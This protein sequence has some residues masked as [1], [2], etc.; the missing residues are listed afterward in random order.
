MHSFRSRIRTSLHPAAGLKRLTFTLV[1]LLGATVAAHA[2][3]IKIAQIVSLTGPLEA[4]GKQSVNGFMLGLEYATGGTM[5][6]GDRKIVV[7]Q[8]DDQSKPDLA[9]AL[10]T[11]A[12]SD[13]KADIGVGGMTTATTLVLLPVAEEHKKILIVDSAISDS[14]TSER[15]NKYLFRVKQNST[16][17]AAPSAAVVDESDTSVA[18]LAQ[19]TTFGREGAAAFKAALTKAKVVHEE[20]VAPM[21]NDF[22]GP[23]QRLIDRLKSLPG[24][25]VIFV[26]TW[27]GPNDPFKIG[28]AGLDRFGI[29]VVAGANI[30][31]AMSQYKRFP[32]ML[33]GI[34]YYY[35]IPKNPTND[36]LVAQHK[37]RFGSPPD[38]YQAYSFAAA[39]AIVAGLTKSKGD[40][41]GDK[42]SIMMEGLSFE[43]PKGTMTFRPQDHQ[44][45][46]SMYQYKIQ[47]Q[48]D[49][50]WAVPVMIKEMKPDTIPLP[51]KNRR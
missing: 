4:Y 10:L 24:K 17:D 22:T 34:S 47:V 51:A 37:K 38:I 14:I 6:V 15:W 11:E 26:N 39:S 19:D 16:Q 45:L 35:E 42:L 49:V 28:D 3:D 8:K 5:R 25:K 21:T 23:A 1:A 32:G 31:P 50:A 48:P 33:G 30:L 46:Q 7:L 9:K 20:F 41:N 43:T 29:T 18:I 44:A 40:T 27:S 36:W 12:F 2:Q 13:E